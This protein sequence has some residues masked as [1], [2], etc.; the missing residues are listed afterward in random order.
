MPQNPALFDN[1]LWQGAT[2]PPGCPYCGGGNAAPSDWYT[3][4]GVQIRS[5]SSDRKVNIALQAPAAGVYAALQNADGTFSVKS[6]ATTVFLAP[7][8]QLQESF[9]QRTDILNT[10]ELGLGTAAGY[11]VTLG[12]YFCRDK[13]N[14][15]HFVEFTFWGLN[16]WSGAT[17]LRGN[18]VPVYD[19][20]VTYDQATASFINLGQTLPTQ[21]VQ[22]GSPVFRGSLSSPFPFVTSSQ[23]T[24][25]PLDQQTLSLAF[26]NGT[27]YD[28]LYRSDMNNF[29]INGRFS[30]RGE[31]DQLVLHPD[32]KWRR[33]CQ[34]GTFMSYLYG[35]RFMQGISTKA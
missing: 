33:E 12:H 7:S 18:L 32:G 20:T 5:H 31:L 9:Q 6:D 11:D 28:Y 24:G 21:L 35:V 8:G 15:D 34:P 30:P 27:E 14:N 29:E 22:N 3:Y 13:N 4:Q 2:V 25:L 16:S 1:G 23:N 26:N 10:R 17:T 19:E